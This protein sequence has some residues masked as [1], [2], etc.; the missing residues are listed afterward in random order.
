[1]TIC[2][3]TRIFFRELW[4]IDL[5][6]VIVSRRINVKYLPMK[7]VIEHKY[8]SYLC[9]RITTCVDFDVFLHLVFPHLVFPPLSIFIYFLFNI[10]FCMFYEE[11]LITIVINR[12]SIQKIKIDFY[13]KIFYNCLIKNLIFNHFEKLK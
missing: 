2:Q 4:L 10:H 5:Y 7:S 6:S 3:E 1:M 12:N 13:K 9:T 11:N 8:L